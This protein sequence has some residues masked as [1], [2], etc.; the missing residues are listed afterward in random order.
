MKK[1][2]RDI[3]LSEADRIYG[4]PHVWDSNPQELHWDAGGYWARKKSPSH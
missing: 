2:R 3:M 4:E 1:K